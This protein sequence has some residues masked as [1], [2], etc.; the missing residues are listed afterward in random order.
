[1]SHNPENPH[2]SITTVHRSSLIQCTLMVPCGPESAISIHVSKCLC[3]TAV[4][5]LSTKFITDRD[6]K[7]R[8]STAYGSENCL[9]HTNTH[10][11]P[12]RCTCCLP[13]YFVMAMV[14][15]EFNGQST[16]AEEP[17]STALWRFPLAK[18]A[19]WSVVNWLF[20]TDPSYSSH[21]KICR[22]ESP[23]YSS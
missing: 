17:H 8:Y 5:Q 13:I 12:R 23:E 7:A 22:P 10:R 19:H 2:H 9:P 21:L 3:G 20:C 6:P 16:W 11:Y 15:R 4:E 1:M 14:M 18:T